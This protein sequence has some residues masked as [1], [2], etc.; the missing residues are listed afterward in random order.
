V[1][2]EVKVVK[3]FLVDLVSVSLGSLQ[4]VSLL[5]LHF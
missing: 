2:C 1:I 5:L 4:F 3:S